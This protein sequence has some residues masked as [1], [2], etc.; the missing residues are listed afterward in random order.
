MSSKI[1]QVY[2]LTEYIFGRT[3]QAWPKS[4]FKASSA[5]AVST[6]GFHAKEMMRNPRCVHAVSRLTGIR[7]A[8]RTTKRQSGARQALRLYE[9]NDGY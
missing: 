4:R 2:Y 7:H 1:S 6:L 5:N 8:S 9:H 3:I